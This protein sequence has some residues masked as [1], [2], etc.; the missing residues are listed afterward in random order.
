MMFLRKSLVWLAVSALPLLLFGLATNLALVRSAGSPEPIKKILK[1][2]K[3]YDS[4][5]DAV[6]EATDNP[7]VDGQAGGIRSDNPIVVAA[8]K[9][10]FPPQLVQSSAENFINGLYG[11]LEG[12]TQTPQFRIDLTAAKATFVNE[13]AAGAEA[14]AAGLPACPRG[15]T[16]FEDAFSATCLPRGV[17]PAAAGDKIRQELAGG[18][19][20]FLK[21]PVITADTLKSKDGK[22]AFSSTSALPE[23]YQRIKKVPIILAG[24]A[25]ISLLVVIFLSESRQKGLKRAGIT[26]LVVGIVLLVFAWAANSVVNKAAIPKINIENSALQ[27]RVKALVKDVSATVSKNFM[28]SGGTYALLGAA[29]IGGAWYI[30]KNSRPQTVKTVSNSNKNASVKR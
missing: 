16:N 19:E 28:L 7:N 29:G 12:S 20:K 9:K 11:W 1:E 23:N 15:Q 24:L 21:D 4:A 22:P 26:L 2:S 3:I 18:E 17:S 10:A 5:L 30:G 13:V 25:L 6:L 14:R 8:A 27:A